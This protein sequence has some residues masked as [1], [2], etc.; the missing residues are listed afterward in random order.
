MRPSLLLLL[1]LSLQGLLR[2]GTS[3]LEELPVARGEWT[4]VSK[5]DERVR[6]VARLEVESKDLVERRVDVFFF[7]P[8]SVATEAEKQKRGENRQDG[9]FTFGKDYHGWLCSVSMAAD[10]DAAI[11]DIHAERNRKDGNIE[12]QAYF[13]VPY[14]RDMKD[15]VARIH[16]TITW[17]KRQPNQPPL[18]MPVSGTPAASA[19]AKATA[20]R[21]APVAPPPGIAGR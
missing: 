4:V 6:L 18:R 21:D 10:C 3:A 20:D 7:V 12:R 13:R 16:F 17:Q 8:T 19:S 9:N 15:E 11:V 1:I 5:D 2:A 14:L